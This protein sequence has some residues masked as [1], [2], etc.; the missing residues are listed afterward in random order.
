MVAEPIGISRTLCYSHI[1]MDRDE[2]RSSEET[3]HATISG[4]DVQFRRSSAREDRFLPDIAKRYDE[5]FEDMFTEMNENDVF[6][7]IG[8]YNGIYSC[9]IGRKYPGIGIVCFEPHP[10]T[11]ESLE[12][13]LQLNGIDATV[14]DYAISNSDGTVSFDTRRNTPGGMG[15]IRHTG[16][17]T[18]TPVRTLDGVVSDDTVSSPTVIMSDI[19]GEEINLLRGGSMTFSLPTTR[20]AYI[21]THDQPLEHLG[22][23]GQDIEELLRSHGFDELEYLRDNLLKA[24]KSD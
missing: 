22:S 19:M 24:K 6:F 2:E 3:I 9:V 8:A 7:D 11:R 20:L 21:V 12:K 17:E 16:R 15:E 5:I 14:M 10:Q 4:V 18:E 13:N 23:S 1:I